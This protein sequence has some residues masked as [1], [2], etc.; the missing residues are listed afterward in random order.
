M[1]EDLTARLVLGTLWLFV[2]VG[3]ALTYRRRKEALNENP[4]DELGD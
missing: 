3:W 2:G 1:R 4:S